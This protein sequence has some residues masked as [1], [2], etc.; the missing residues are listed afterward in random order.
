MVLIEGISPL[1]VLG[2]DALQDLPVQIMGPGHA[3][4]EGFHIRPAVLV[5]SD[6]DDLGLMPQDQAQISARSPVTHG[7][8][9]RAL[10]FSSRSRSG[11]KAT[12]AM[13]KLLTPCTRS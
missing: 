12:R 4:D 7:R 1:L 5:Q 9:L 8:I 3:F 2:H 11:T 10:S 13:R 6:A